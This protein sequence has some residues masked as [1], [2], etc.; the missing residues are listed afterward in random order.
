MVRK[1]RED[2]GNEDLIRSHRKPEGMGHRKIILPAFCAIVHLQIFCKCIKVGSLL[3]NDSV[4]A[5]ERSG[6]SIVPRDNRGRVTRCT[7]G[8]VP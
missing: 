6:T 7:V 8:R 4:R 1:T 5:R 2:I 3:M